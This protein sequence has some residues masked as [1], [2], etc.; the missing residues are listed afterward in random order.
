MRVL[1]V[2]DN[3]TTRRVVYEMLTAGGIEMDEAEDGIEGL[4]AIEAGEHDLILM[5]LRMP[6]MDGLTAIRA[7]R[8]RDDAKAKL[9]VIVITADAGST[10]RADCMAAGADEMILK[11]VVMQDLYAAIGTLLASGD[12]DVVLA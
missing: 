1:F 7:L 9:P 12:G 11:P 6:R 10:I 2:E 5:D 4:E 3:A 8:A